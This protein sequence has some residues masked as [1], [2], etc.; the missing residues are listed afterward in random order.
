MS[1]KILFFGN[2]RLATGVTTKTPTFLRLIE[3]G[4]EVAALILAQNPQAQSRALRETEIVSSAKEHNVPVFYLNK[5]SE[6]IDQIK[7]FNASAGILIAY[8]K[9]VPQSV[10]DIFPR[11]IINIHPSLLPLHRGPT[12]LESV[13]LAGDQTTGISLM[14]L[15][16]KMDAGPVYAQ[17]SIALPKLATK[18]DMANELSERGSRL[19][20]GHLPKILDGTLTP[21]AQEGQ[22]TYDKLIQKNDGIL[23]WSKTAIE[24]ERQVRAFSSWPRSSFVLNDIKLVVTEAHVE[25][26]DNPLVHTKAWPQNDQGHEDDTVGAIVETDPRTLGFRTAR[27]VFMIDKL[28]P[29]GRKEMTAAAFLSGYRPTS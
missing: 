21:S 1:K 15:T 5:L 26:S 18:Q 10:I 17:T 19:L 11:G 24:L 2:E 14:Q 7:E 8:G 29:S 20:I 9:M 16:S 22:P 28:L 12:P 25:T 13:L 27:D 23:D 4:Y 6:S 3:E